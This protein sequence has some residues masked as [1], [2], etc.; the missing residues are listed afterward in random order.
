MINW[1]DPD[2]MID[3]M[4]IQEYNKNIVRKRCIASYCCFIISRG[5]K[6]AYDH[7]NGKQFFGMFRFRKLEKAKRQGLGGFL[8]KRN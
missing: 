2:R 5:I 4:W 3:F 8:W 6:E 7:I 1:N